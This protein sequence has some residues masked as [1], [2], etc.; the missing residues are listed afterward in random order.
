MT[1]ENARIID[2]VGTDKFDK[3]VVLTIIDHLD[4]SNEYEHLLFIQDKVNAYLEFI[5]SGQIYISYPD[6]AGR[7]IKLSLVSKFELP[8]S[9][10]KLLEQ[11]AKVCAQIG[12]TIVHIV[13]E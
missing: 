9:A 6:A 5:Q 7:K 12:V 13:R 4:W 8:D 10:I 3:S 2:A 1:V 11:I